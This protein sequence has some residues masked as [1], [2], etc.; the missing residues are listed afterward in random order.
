MDDEIA[1]GFISRMGETVKALYEQDFKQ[2]PDGSPSCNYCR[3][4][5]FCRRTHK[6]YS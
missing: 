5:D 4:I 3:F 6:R 2:A 1:K